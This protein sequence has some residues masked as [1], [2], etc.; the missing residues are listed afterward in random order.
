MKQSHP[1]LLTYTKYNGFW[2]VQHKLNQVKLILIAKIPSQDMIEMTLIV[3]DKNGNFGTI[4]CTMNSKFES[5]NE[6]RMKQVMV[7]LVK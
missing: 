2:P 3:F 6:F 5:Y 1:V 4:F 7:I